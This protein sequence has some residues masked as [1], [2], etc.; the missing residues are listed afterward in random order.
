M[1]KKIFSFAL[2]ISAQFVF[3]QN[4]IDAMRYSQTSAYGDARFTAMAGSFGALGANLSCMNFNP[5]GISMYRNGE[6]VFTPAIKLQAADAMHYGTTT[7]DGL[8]KLNVSNLGFVTAWNSKN[9]Y[10][11]SSKEYADFNQRNAI[12]LSYNRLA[13][14]NAHTT[15]EGHPDNSS[16]IN[17]FVNVAQGYYP[18]KLNSQYEWLAYQTYLI[19]PVSA[20]DSAHYWGMMLPNTPLKQ[21]K[22]IKESGRMGELAFSYAHAFSDKFYVGATVSRINVTYGRESTYQEVDDKSQIWPFKSLAYNEKLLTTGGGYN[23]KL[24]GIYRVNESLRLGAYFHTPTKLNL[25]DQ[26]EYKMNTTYDTSITSQGTDY[27]AESSGGFKYS[28]TTPAR[29][30]GSICYIYKKLLAINADAEYINYGSAKM[31]DADGYLDGINLTIASKY[32][33]TTNLRVGAELNIRPVVIRL[34]YASYGSPFGQS[35]AGKF[36]RSTY[37]GGVGFRGPRNVYVDLGLMYTAWQDEYYLFDA[38][39][40]N[41]SQISNGVIY[42]T[43][44][45]GV[46]FN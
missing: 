9:N 35:F 17:D 42:F 44:T 4:D 23:L 31:H 39:Y 11:P 36:V 46:K 29:F 25:T 28:I 8:G 34:G 7:G 12:G 27:Y 38:K 30:G 45:L 33:S 10:P 16:I 37:S 6:F 24:G 43:A 15:I 1:I 21:I 5:A 2:F 20:S 13:D 14:F 41:V 32:K 3:A 26:Y 19:N 40:V 18:S 22:T